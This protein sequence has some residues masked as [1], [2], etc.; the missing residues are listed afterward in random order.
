MEMPLD[1]DSENYLQVYE[2]VASMVAI[3]GSKPPA[4]LTGTPGQAAPVGEIHVDKGPEEARIG[5]LVQDIMSCGDYKTLETY[6]LLVKGKAELEAAYET[7]KQQI[8]AAEKQMILQKTEELCKT[9][10]K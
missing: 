4:D 10:A 1:F 6:K 3:C 5:I 7:R 9:S 8:F 2:N